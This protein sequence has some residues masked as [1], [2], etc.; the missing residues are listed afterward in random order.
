[1]SLSQLSLLSFQWKHYSCACG[2]GGWWWG[3]G[4]KYRSERVVEGYPAPVS[5]WRSELGWR[6]TRP[7]IVVLWRRGV[8]RLNVFDAFTQSTGRGGGVFAF[9]QTAGDQFHTGRHCLER[10]VSEDP[11][12]RAGPPQQSQDVCL[13][14]SRLIKSFDIH[15]A[16]N[17][18]LSPL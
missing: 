15:D 14:G 2:L 9:L 6:L 12:R 4:L 5:L 13:S 3:G 11:A 1:M 17:P 7:S 10:K 16:N 18:S 8:G